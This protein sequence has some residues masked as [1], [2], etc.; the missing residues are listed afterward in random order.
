MDVDVVG[1]CGCERGHCE[2][3]DMGMG[4]ATIATLAISTPLLPLAIV[5]TTTVTG[6]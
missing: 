1:G 4:A 5:I 2:A 3:V 6:S